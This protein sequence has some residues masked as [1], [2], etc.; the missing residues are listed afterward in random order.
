[1]RNDM[2]FWDFCGSGCAM[3][4]FFCIW[5][6]DTEPSFSS[7][8]MIRCQ[9]ARSGP[10]RSTDHEGISFAQTQRRLRR[11]FHSAPYLAFEFSFKSKVSLEG[12][13]VKFSHSSYNY[14]EFLT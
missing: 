5:S 2:H 10:Q 7:P 3:A 6:N 9:P 4:G 14:R 1:M 12:E 13:G 8:S 11:L